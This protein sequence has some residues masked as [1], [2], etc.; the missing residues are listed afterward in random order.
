MHRKVSTTGKVMAGAVALVMVPVVGAA[1]PASPNRALVDPTITVDVSNLKFDLGP[2]QLGV[3]QD[4]WYDDA[5]GLWDDTTD[6]PRPDTA[7]KAT[8]AGV[9]V[10]RFPGGTPAGLFNWKRAIGDPAQRG[11]QMIG[12]VPHHEAATDNDYGP[13]EFSQLADSVGAE[14]HIMV[15]IANESPA[16]AAA[17]VEYMNAAVG[18]NP[19]GGIAWADVRAGHGYSEP[20]GVEHWEIGNEPDRNGQGYWLGPDGGPLTGRLARYIDGAELAQDNVALGRDCDFSQ[21][22]SN[23]TAGQQFYFLYGLI[24]PGTSPT[25]KV[26]SATWTETADLGTAGP[27]DQVYGL[28]RDNGTVTFGD[29]IH[30]A[31]PVMGEAVTASYTFRHDGF[32]AMYDAMKSTA[33]QIGTEINVCSTWAPVFARNTDPAQVNQPS[34]AEAMATRGSADGYDCVAI[35]PYTNFRR[36]FGLA[37]AWVGPLDGH[38]DHMLGDAWA[39]T[40]VRTLKQDV[41]AHSLPGADGRAAYTTVSEMGA[42]WFA[43]G[44]TPDPGDNFPRYAASMTH[45]LYMASQFIHHTRRDVRLIEGNTLVAG[46]DELRSMLGGAN[47]GYVFSAE[48]Y[49]RQAMKPFYSTGSRWVASEI[50]NNPVNVVESKGEYPILVTGASLG[51]DGALRIVVVNR[52][53]N[54]AQL[55]QVAPSGFTHSGTVEVATVKGNAFDS[56]NDGTGPDAPGDDSVGLTNSTV[57][58]NQ[59]FSYTFPAASVTVL[60]LRPGA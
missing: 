8:Q 16:D 26:G 3:N 59:T 39:A 10:L 49:T 31:I 24:K 46:D 5:H 36:D 18:T 57:Q 29:G 44:V 35:H 42:L 12:N 20:F 32:V 37:D 45:A 17:W 4:H 25:V 2:A 22:S 55:A 50:L 60:T 51:A 11:C 47:F 21:T 28:D 30:G 1:A 48:A 41:D 13:A 53:P 40:M 7:A 15:P 27:T 38:N 14:K 52:R 33:A 9:G 23:G 34:F 19:D 6:A 58:K 56:Y 43:G 54:N